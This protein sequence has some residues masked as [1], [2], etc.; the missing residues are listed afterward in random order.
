MFKNKNSQR[1]DTIVEV[2]LAMA[3]IGMVLGAA[4]G[5]ANRSVAIG[6][7]AQERTEALK[8]AESQVEL[9]KTLYPSSSTMQGRLS[10]EPFCIDVSTSSDADATDAACTNTNGFGVSGLYSIA[11]TKPVDDLD[12]TEDPVKI[13]ITWERL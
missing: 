12:A 6:R 2:L 4:F 9:L 5:I 1:G 11:I 7:S 8:I 3:V 13:S 10:S